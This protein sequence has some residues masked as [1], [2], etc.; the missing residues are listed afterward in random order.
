MVLGHWWMTF[1]E[2]IVKW[3]F[4]YSNEQKQIIYRE[5]GGVHNEWLQSYKKNEN[6]TK[7]SLPQTKPM[8]MEEIE[9]RLEKTVQFLKKLDEIW[10]EN[11]NWYEK[12]GKIFKKIWTKIYSLTL[13]MTI[14]LTCLYFT[15]KKQKGK[16]IL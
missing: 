13:M 3:K 14:H 7:I 12:V 16:H 9:L 4:F 1:S 6:Q 5:A 15:E 10:F 11:D 8:T 2:V